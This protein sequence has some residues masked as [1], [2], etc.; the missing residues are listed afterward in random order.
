M[1]I[2]LK[3]I[4][5]SVMDFIYEKQLEFTKAKKKKI[6]LERTVAIL[7]ESA[8]LTRKKQDAGKGTAA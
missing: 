4:P 5:A 1:A 7:L 3:N 8:Y 6:G 2:L